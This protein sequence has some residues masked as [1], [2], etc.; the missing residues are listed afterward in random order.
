MPLRLWKQRLF[1][2]AKFVRENS[3]RNDAD[4]IGMTIELHALEFRL[5]SSNTKNQSSF[6]RREYLQAQ[7]SLTFSC[8]HAEKNKTRKM[9]KSTSIERHTSIRLGVSQRTESWPVLLNFSQCNSAKF[10]RFIDSFI[11]IFHLGSEFGK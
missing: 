11:H 9:Q 6:M 8:I 10:I 4:V 7:T 1:R 5:F 3:A 2:D